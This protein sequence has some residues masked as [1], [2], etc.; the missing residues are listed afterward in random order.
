MLEQEMHWS[1]CCSFGQPAVRK[2]A[3]FVAVLYFVAS[4]WALTYHWDE[5]VNSANSDSIAN[6]LIAMY[7]LNYLRWMYF[8]AIQ[9][10]REIIWWSRANCCCDCN[11]NDGDC[12]FVASQEEMHGCCCSNNCWHCCDVSFTLFAWLPCLIY[13]IILIWFVWPFFIQEGAMV[14]WVGFSPFAMSLAFFLVI[15]LVLTAC[16]QRNAVKV[17]AL[18]PVAAPPAQLNA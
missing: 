8:M 6:C 18:L 4:I 2:P 16:K 9:I 13:E 7:V 15:P 17:H 3:I 11:R 12:S 1:C 10:P 5:F 14:V